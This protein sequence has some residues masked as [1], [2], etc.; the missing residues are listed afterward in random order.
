LAVAAQKLVVLAPMDLLW[1]D[2]LPPNQVKSPKMAASAARRMKNMAM[3]FEEFQ[4]SRDYSDDLH[5]IG[6]CEGE[7][8]VYADGLCCIEK[9]GAVYLLHSGDRTLVDTDLAKLEHELYQRLYLAAA[10]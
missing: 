9:S 7:G 8:F 10:A 1:V 2:F 6:L 3:S 5:A 4:G